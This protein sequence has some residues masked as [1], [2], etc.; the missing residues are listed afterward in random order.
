MSLERY[1]SGGKSVSDL[2]RAIQKRSRFAIADL[3]GEALF[4]LFPDGID[5]VIGV[6]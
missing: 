5:A 6:L 4:P 1:G 3:Q 2:R